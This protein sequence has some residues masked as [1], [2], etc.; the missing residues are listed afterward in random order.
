ML[1]GY[2]HPLRTGVLMSKE[3]T[4]GADTPAG[5]QNTGDRKAALG[6]SRL[7]R[8]RPKQKGENGGRT[9]SVTQESVELRYQGVWTTEQSGQG[10]VRFGRDVLPRT[11]QA[12]CLDSSWLLCHT[13]SSQEKGG[14]SRDGLLDFVDCLLE[15]DRWE[16]S[17]APS[18]L[19]PLQ[20]G[21]SEVCLLF[22]HLGKLKV[23][24]Q[25]RWRSRIIMKPLFHGSGHIQGAQTRFSYQLVSE[26]FSHRA[27]KQGLCLGS[28]L[29]QPSI[30]LCML[31][32]QSWG[33]GMR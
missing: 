1:L 7:G 32:G 2:S 15:E 4:Q 22:L 27:L 3:L 6:Q 12:C 33:H 10:Q 26:S 8:F 23:G 24:A 25:L 30:S 14:R 19:F 11:P 18:S 20:H 9:C 29:Q 5:L 13:K 21:I 31:G 28:G 17:L 16:R